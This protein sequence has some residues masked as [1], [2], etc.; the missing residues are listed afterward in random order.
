VLDVRKDYFGKT[1]NQEGVL[2]AQPPE[3]GLRITNIKNI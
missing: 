2:L 1:I 3:T